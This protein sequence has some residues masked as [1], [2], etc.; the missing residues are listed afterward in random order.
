MKCSDSKEAPFAPPNFQPEIQ[1]ARSFLYHVAGLSSSNGIATNNLSFSYFPL[2]TAE[3]DRR[4]GHEDYLAFMLGNHIIIVQNVVQCIFKQRGM[5]ASC[6]SSVTYFKESQHKLIAQTKH[7]IMFFQSSWPNHKKPISYHP[8]IWQV[9]V[10][11]LAP[12]AAPM[13]SS[14]V[15]TTFHAGSEIE[16]G[17][18]G[19]FSRD[20][21]RP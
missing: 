12:Q 7:E 1:T 2:F 5:R 19:L 8:P 4:G 13:S 18:L 21:V 16:V 6:L 10:P 3:E 11:Y 9:G 17:E 20:N 15:D 14:E